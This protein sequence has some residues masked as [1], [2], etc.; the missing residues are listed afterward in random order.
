MDSNGFILW[1]ICAA[2]ILVA[3]D[4]FDR[5]HGWQMFTYGSP[6]GWRGS[7]IRKFRPTMI[8]QDLASVEPI[9][10]QTGQIF[11][12]R[13]IYGS[14]DPARRYPA[15]DDVV[16][17]C[18]PEKDTSELTLH[19]LKNRERRSGNFVVRDRGDWHIGD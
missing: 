13:H 1:G 6:W 12:I 15:V 16:V 5:K 19:L 8:V 4:A 3:G 7:Y 11:T 17:L 2:L 14:V 9:Q 10:R 18:G